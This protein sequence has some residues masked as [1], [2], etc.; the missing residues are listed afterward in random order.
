MTEL[1]ETM[2]N[3]SGLKNIL[4]TI[5]LNGIMITVEN[6]GGGLL[7]AATVCIIG[8][9]PTKIQTMSQQKIPPLPTTAHQIPNGLQFLFP[10]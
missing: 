4:K 3:L 1:S 9:P 8:A 10:E 6:S 5:Q 7:S 2:M